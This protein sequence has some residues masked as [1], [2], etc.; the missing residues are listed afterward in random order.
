MTQ[1]LRARAL[2]DGE[3]GA[4]EIAT[5]EGPVELRF[6]LEDAERLIDDLRAARG[7]I[8]QGRVH[9]GSAPLPEKP[10]TVRRWETA[11]DPVNQTAVL[12]A[13]YS[14]GTVHD[15]RI[16]RTELARIVD[17]LQQA[18]KRLEPGSDMRQ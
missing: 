4:I 2:A 3:G 18:L 15:T 9:S 10:K 7:R 12:R 8:Q 11:V 1:L 16:A 13:H 14:D 5:T 17:F 6:T